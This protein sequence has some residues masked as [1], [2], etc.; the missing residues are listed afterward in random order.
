MLPES[1]PEKQLSPKQRG[2]IWKAEALGNVLFLENPD[3]ATLARGG[4]SHD[5][6]ARKLMA[7]VYEDYPAVAITAVRLLMRKLIPEEERRSLGLEHNKTRFDRGIETGYFQSDFHQR[8]SREGGRKR[9]QALQIPLW[10]ADQE[11]TI[12][13]MVSSPSFQR[14]VT[15]SHP[16]KPNWQ[17]ITDALNQEFGHHRSINTVKKKYK[18]IQNKAA[19]NRIC[20]VNPPLVFSDRHSTKQIEV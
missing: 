16:G 4:L 7:Q 12:V 17:Q 10:T 15:S 3:I 8:Q 14:P 6:I 13:S 1:A 9:A 19:S 11:I 5:Q 2:L 18:E 20:S